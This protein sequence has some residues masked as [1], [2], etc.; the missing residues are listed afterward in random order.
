M[1]NDTEEHFG[2]ITKIANSLENILAIEIEPYHFLGNS[3]YEKLGKIGKLHCFEQ[4]AE[5][6]VEDWIMQVKKHTKVI[7][8]RA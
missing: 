2:G 1:V 5:Q 6:Q 8:K 7:V 4:P 3:K